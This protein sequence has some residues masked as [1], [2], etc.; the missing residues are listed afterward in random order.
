M[1][2]DKYLWSV[3]LFKT[4]TMAAQAIKDGKIVI[5][6]NEVKS[7]YEVKIN[8]E[9]LLKSGSMRFNY[10]VI[11]FPK[12]RVGAKLVAEYLTDITDEE[13]KKRNQIILDNKKNNAFFEEGRPTKKN[14]R[15]ID[16]WMNDF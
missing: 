16:K 7:S 4:R 12:T 10:K 6:D 11:A 5:N 15:A 9:F 14:R 3:R 13:N 8:D 1:R 2:I